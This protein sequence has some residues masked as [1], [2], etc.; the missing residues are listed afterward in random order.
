MSSA[1][2]RIDLRGK[3]QLFYGNHVTNCAEGKLYIKRKRRQNVLCL[4]AAMVLVVRSL[5]VLPLLLVA[6]DSGLVFSQNDSSPFKFRIGDPRN[7]PLAKEV[8]RFEVF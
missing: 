8:Y 3:T 7:C 5:L 1:T 4:N 6:F 2:E